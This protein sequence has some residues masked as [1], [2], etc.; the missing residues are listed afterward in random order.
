MNFVQELTP[1]K[2]HFPDLERTNFEGTGAR[3]DEGTQDLKLAANLL[4]R[5]LMPSC[6]RALQCN[7]RESMPTPTTYNR[8]RSK[9]PKFRYNEPSPVSARP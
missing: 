7:R 4:L 3:G 2:L 1:N 5:A 6:P 9:V 8:G